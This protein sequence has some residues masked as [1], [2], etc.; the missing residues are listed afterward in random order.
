MKSQ[1]IKFTEKELENL[2]LPTKANGPVTYYDIGCS[3]G[4]CVIVS[5]GGSKT[6]YFLTYFNGQT[7]RVKLGKVGQLKLI[8]ARK[9]AHSKKEQANMGENPSQERREVLNDIIFKDFYLNHYMPRHSEAYKKLNSIKKDDTLYRNRLKSFHNRKLLSITFDDIDKLHKKINKDISCYSANRMLTLVSHMYT[10]AMEW[11]I[12][13]R[14][15][16]NP[17]FGIKK[18]REKSRD[19]FMNGEEIQRFFAALSVEIND[20]FRNYVILSLFLGQRRN[21]ILG[22]RWSDVDL[23]NGLVYFAETKN[24]DP[25]QV[26]LTTHSAKLLQ[27][28]KNKSDSE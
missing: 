28:I 14:R 11:K 6:Y 10:K 9:I 24:G 23:V 20:V 7:M 3:D 13:P 16:G 2:P 4:L 15:L 22:M 19:R 1:H 8:D 25:L 21:N 12:Y 18:F 26:P 27:D 5:Y 17:A